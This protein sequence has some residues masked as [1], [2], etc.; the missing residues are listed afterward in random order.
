MSSYQ[1]S[2]L[3]ASDSEMEPLVVLEEGRKDGLLEIQATKST[4]PSSATSMS[5]RGFGVRELSSDESEEKGGA[6]SSNCIQDLLQGLTLEDYLGICVAAAYSLVA[7]V[8]AVSVSDHETMRPYWPY[9][10]SA[11]QATSLALLGLKLARLTGITNTRASQDQVKALAN[12]L[13]IY[14]VESNDQIKALRTELVQTRTELVQKSDAT[15]TELVHNIEASRDESN[16]QFIESRRVI[17]NVATTAAATNTALATL[18]GTVAT[19]QE[20]VGNVNTNLNGYQVETRNLRAAADRL[21]AVVTNV[22]VNHEGRIHQLETAQRALRNVGNQ[23][24]N[25][26]GGN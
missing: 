25:G 17:D 24:Q 13:E 8:T 3:A 4:S 5:R 19:L 1:N 9:I 20:T 23:Q 21:T 10:N 7:G 12:Q 16:A 15:R 6:N 14:R 22:C 11:T 26:N 2:I 18:Q